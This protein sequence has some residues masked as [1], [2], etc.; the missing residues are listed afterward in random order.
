M[1]NWLLKQ[2]RR[3]PDVIKLIILTPLFLWG[4]H[5]LIFVIRTDRIR[6]F[7]IWTGRGAY[8]LDR[9]PAYVPDFLEP[10]GVFAP[11]TCE[12]LGIVFAIHVV[13]AILV[14]F[15]GALSRTKLMGGVEI[16]HPLDTSSLAAVVLIVGPAYWIWY[17]AFKTRDEGF[18]WF[19]GT[20]ITGTSFWP[21][22]LAHAVL[23]AK[24]PDLDGPTT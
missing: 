18:W 8:T 3:L 7:F 6:E 24:H 5:R 10:F 22:F 15:S 9:L 16:C 11:F 13:S 17:L 19:F 1:Y 12:D 4:F 23:Q 14:F 21:L 2:I 20:F